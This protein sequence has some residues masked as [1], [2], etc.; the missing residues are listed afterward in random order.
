MS[1]LRRTTALLGLA[2][3]ASTIVSGAPPAEAA[4]SSAPTVDSLGAYVEVVNAEK[5]VHD[6]GVMA[7]P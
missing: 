1:L 4:S 3:A 7:E 2:V 6:V 5:W